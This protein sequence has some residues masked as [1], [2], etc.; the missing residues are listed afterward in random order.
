MMPG[1]IGLVVMFSCMLLA[2]ISLVQEKSSGVFTRTL[3]TPT[4][5]MLTVVT[6]TISNLILSGI[7]IAI[8]LAVGI[9]MY[10]IQ[11]RGELLDV[12]ITGE[13]VSLSF[14]TVGLVIGA[15]SK[16]ENTSI[17]ASI[18]VGLPMLFLCGLLFPTELMPSLMR[19]VSSFLP[20]TYG[21]DAMRNI[22]VYGMAI[23]QVLVPLGLLIV[24][25]LVAFW[26][27]IKVLKK[28]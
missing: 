10:N 25:S 26:I 16:S 23:D 12:F 6:R 27:S 28:I 17:L 14:L 22:V 7:Q 4:P 8:L 19:V 13:A 11:I 9:L 21:I 20:L 15:F 18:S 1:I 24:Q 5:L 2:S 3:L